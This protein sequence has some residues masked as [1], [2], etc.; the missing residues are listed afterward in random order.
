MMGYI[1][2]S[3]VI[4][5]AGGSDTCYNIL[6]W[7]WPFIIEVILIAPLSVGI[8]FIP[9]DLI[10]VKVIHGNSIKR[11]N[12]I[13]LHVKTVLRSAS[14]SSFGEKKE[15]SRGSFNQIDLTPLHVIRTSSSTASNKS[16]N[17]TF[18]SNTSTN[19][20]PLLYSKINSGNNLLDAD[21]DILNYNST[22]NEIK[23]KKDSG[24]IEALKV[25]PI[26][27][28]LLHTQ[29]ITYPISLSEDKEKDINKSDI[30]LIDKDLLTIEDM[31]NSNLHN[32]N[33][34]NT[35]KESI[36]SVKNESDFNLG[37]PILPDGKFSTDLNNYD[38]SEKY[39]VSEE[40]GSDNET[41]SEAFLSPEKSVEIHERRR[42][43]NQVSPFSSSS[44]FIF[45]FFFFYYFF[46][47]FY[48]SSSS[49]SLTFIRLHHYVLPL[50]PLLSSSFPF[51]LRPLFFLYLLFS[52][53]SFFLVNLFI[54]FS[55]SMISS[56]NNLVII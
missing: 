19:R 55:C 2:A 10:S 34:N 26:H 13:Q 33:E 25:I 56:G 48:F 31:N 41:H 21:S 39:I 14:M 28:N 32:P 24:K 52:F 7:R 11:K 22:S 49:F 6:C 1:I 40:D 17:P 20:T 8:F 30:D 46:F 4:G 27:S 35:E 12:E 5:F 42:L 45:F 9:K 37:I 29:T 47:F 38:E 23:E 3:V 15:R 43:R 44:T 54:N 16:L 51:F 18:P 36:K 50:L 53:S